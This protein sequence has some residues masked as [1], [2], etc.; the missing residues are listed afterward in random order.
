MPSD[1]ACRHG[2]TTNSTHDDEPTVIATPEAVLTGHPVGPRSNGA[3][4]IS[5]GEALHETDI[6]FAY[7]YRCAEAADWIVS[8]LYCLE[9]APGRVR[10]PTLGVTEVLVGGRLGTI[11]LPTA[12]THRQ[13]LTELQSRAV[14]PPTDGCGP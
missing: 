12:R 7:A 11:T 8:R 2:S 1:D 5:C 4:C 13:C 3:V 6:V 9:C 10:S 14:S